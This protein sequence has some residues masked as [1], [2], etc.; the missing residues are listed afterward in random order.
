[1]HIVRLHCGGLVCG[2]S[3]RKLAARATTHDLVLLW[4]YSTVYG[5]IHDGGINGRFLLGSWHDQNPYAVYVLNT[6]MFLSFLATFG[7]GRISVR[8]DDLMS[9]ELSWLP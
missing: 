4:S 3:E 1:M 7:F 8:D 6:R 2:F 5:S 9:S